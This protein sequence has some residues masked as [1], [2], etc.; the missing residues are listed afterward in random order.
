RGM[1]I[2]IPRKSHRNFSKTCGS[3]NTTTQIRQ[4]AKSKESMTAAVN[5]D[6]KELQDHLNTTDCGPAYAAAV[7]E[8]KKFDFDQMIRDAVNECK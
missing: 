3:K 2:V 5:R 6:T 8:L 1:A 4:D 7:K